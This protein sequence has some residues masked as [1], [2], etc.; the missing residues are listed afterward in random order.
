MLDTIKS[1]IADLARPFSIVATSASAAA[2]TVIIALKV[3]GFEGAAIFIGAVYAGLA[4]LYGW[5]S[6][7]KRGEAK[8][9]AEV[10]VAKAGQSQV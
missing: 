3:D 7:E 4:G 2:A 9:A 1:F 6:W 5:K 8:H 10:E